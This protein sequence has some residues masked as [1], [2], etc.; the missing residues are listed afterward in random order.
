MRLKKIFTICFI[1]LTFF[2]VNCNHVEATSADLNIFSDAAILIDSKTGNV[3]CEKNSNEKMY[4][5]STTKI[6]TAI[7][8][9]EKC[10]LNEKVTASYEAVMSIPVGYSNA[11]IQ[12]G[13]T[14]TVK[15]LLDVFLVHSANEAGYILA[16][17]ISGSISEFAVLM[18]E[19]ASRI[20]CKN[21]NFV[22]PSGIHN[23]E[24]YSTALDMALIA[25]YCMQNSTFRDIVSQTSCKVAATDKYQERF[26][27]NTN[28]LIKK[29]SK[30]YYEYAIGIKTGYT[31]QAKNCLISASLKD[32]LEL[33]SVVLGAEQTNDGRSAR[34]VD[35]KTLFE[36]GFDNYSFETIANKN[37]VIQELTIKNATKD[38][39][40][41]KLLLKDSIEATISNDIK[42]DTLNPK[43]ELNDE[44]LAPIAE[45]SVL[46]TITYEI[47][48]VKYSEDL[49]ASHAVEKSNVLLLT[50]QIVGVIL[51]LLILSRL[52][53]PKKRRPK[54]KKIDSIYSFK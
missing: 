52:L 5:A 35:S 11:A 16:E 23:S 30:Y 3:L 24:H 40:N 47:D 17:H 45:N 31:T 4:P 54:K 1:F 28:D 34:Y 37:D 51:I 48:G 8:A 15:E 14:L 42:I 43:I 49:I 25:R 9:L 20:G 50:V 26:F 32:N 13:E 2:I 29:S 36:Y 53:V 27:A 10:D 33:I 44:I 18:N 7:I 12:P 39:K 19:T 46:G 38:T 21:S 22:N 6:L 41:L